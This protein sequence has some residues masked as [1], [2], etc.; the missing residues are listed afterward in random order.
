MVFVLGTLHNGDWKGGQREQEGVQ[1]KVLPFGEGSEV[2][3]DL[4]VGGTG[5]KTCST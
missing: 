4:I 2:L 1:T 3:E 5:G